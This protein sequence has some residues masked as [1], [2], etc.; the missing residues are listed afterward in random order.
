MKHKIRFISQLE[1]SD[2]GIACARI[3]ARYY[4]KK[5]P[6][7]YLLSICEV[8][9]TGLSVRELIKL[10]SSIELES[11]GIKINFD[12]VFEVP[13]P[14]I[15]LIDKLHYVVLYKITDKYFYIMDPQMGK[16]KLSHYKF[17]KRWTFDGKDGI[18][19]LVDKTEKFDSLKFNKE[20]SSKFI[21]RI[22][23]KFF[24]KNK[25]FYSGIFI[26][27]LLTMATELLIPILLKNTVDIGIKSKDIGLV[28]LL[29]CSQL[30]IFLGNFIT[31]NISGFIQTKLS[32]NIGLDMMYD[33]F[34]KLLDKSSI[35]F[36]RKFRADLLN[37]AEDQLAIKDYIIATPQDLFFSI[38]SLFLFS[39]I[40]IY[41]SIT[42]FIVFFGLTFVCFIWLIFF[43]QRHV[44][45][46]SAY[47]ICSSQKNNLLL[48]LIAG[49]NDIKAFGAEATHL[50]RWK[51]LQINLNT[52]SVRSF[53]LNIIESGGNSVISRCRDLILTGI[54]ASLVIKGSMSLGVMFMVSYIIGCLGRP[55]QSILAS[56]IR[57][58]DISIAY[59]RVHEIMTLDDIS[60]KKTDVDKITI[61][62][63]QTITLKNLSF[64]YSGAN[65]PYI[66]KD[67]N[68]IIKRN[69]TIAIVG[70][71][72]CGKTTFLKILS[73]LFQPTSGQITINKQE[74]LDHYNKAWVRM[75]G[76][77]F[78]DGTIFTTTV[79]ENICLNKDEINIEKIKEAA[80][81][82]CINDFI[83]KLPM[84]Y[85]TPIGKGGLELS[86][87]QKQRILIARAFYKNPEIII[88]DEATSS[89]DA[90]TEHKIMEN[91]N[92]FKSKKTI[93]IAAHRLSTIMNADTIVLM[94][95]G[96][97]CE[98]GNHHELM[99]AKGKYYNLIQ[100]QISDMS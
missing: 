56:Y 77:V 40:L 34:S 6:N 23:K 83:S 53:F 65:A 17:K 54:C 99:E 5:I 88:L 73:G 80:K 26:L 41:Y 86:G 55:F 93:I 30:G 81:L 32:M 62:K 48:E 68:L 8:S 94:N 12:K 27:T 52:L 10:L 87:G 60:E 31:S 89:L 29:I 61:K 95:D 92:K 76:N 7:E 64:K 36:N 3:I 20:V 13:L 58:Q 78:Q 46:N 45:L 66:I 1:Q 16:Y 33:Y 63:F 2:C 50:N 19:I 51:E 35:F 47:N 38:L 44:S 96:H 57:Y 25:K 67:L 97:F 37:K 9:R 84:G 70:E 85:Y 11:L 24:S 98:I 49:I 71:S 74:T 59:D 28:W 22:L 4:G 91:I 39:G 72:G 79:A 21:F 69:Q 90:E 100:S 42:I 18:T 14:C 15:I 75:C 82:A 43:K